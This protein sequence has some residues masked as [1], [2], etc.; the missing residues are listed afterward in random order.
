MTRMQNWTRLAAALGL[1]TIACDSTWAAEQPTTEQQEQLK[2]VPEAV[3]DVYDGFWHTTSLYRMPESW[4]PHKSPWKFCYNESYMG[5]TWRA[6]ILAQLQKQVAAYAKAG[7]S[8]GDLVVT[9][10]NNNITLQLTQLNSLVSQ[11]CDVIF[12][13][14]TSPTGLCTGV[15][16][17]AQKGVLFVTMESPVVCPEAVNVAQNAYQSSLSNARWLADAMG[18]KGNILVVQG[19]AGISL[20]VARQKAIDQMLSEYPQIK[21]LGEVYGNWTAATAKTETLKFVATHPQQIDGVWSG[22]LMG[23][24]TV[25]G[26][27]QSGRPAVP[28]AD[29]DNE[30]NWVAYMHA[31]GGVPTRALVD[32]GG[33]V[34]FEAFSVAARILAGQRPVVNTIFYTSPEISSK[35]VADYYDPSMTLQST[36]WADPKDGRLVPDSYIDQFLSGG[37]KLPVELTP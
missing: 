6:N 25:E 15:R 27:G 21:K 18:G 17:A 14:P 24:A 8:K 5:N 36:C 23:L 2:L 3:R 35:N 13:F 34:A 30:C 32:G 28:V 31:N 12:S 26:L 7:L 1:L 22:G 9:N 33:P 10:S 16:D 37:Q 11:G 29:M 4:Q 19:I 20:T